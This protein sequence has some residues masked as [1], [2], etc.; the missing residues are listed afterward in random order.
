[1]RRTMA[2]GTGPV[3][4]ALILGATLSLVAL[5]GLTPAIAGPARIGPR[6]ATASGP[7]PCVP[8]GNG[9]GETCTGTFSGDLAP[10]PFNPGGFLP[11]APTVTVSQTQNLTNQMV[12]VTWT[13]FESSFVNVPNA[14][15]YVP[16]QT[17][18]AVAIVECRGTPE[19]DTTNGIGSGGPNG[20]CYALAPGTQS[21]TAAG[22]G[23]ELVTFT[24]Q[25][26]NDHGGTGSA[27]FQIET[28]Q[29]NTFLGCSDTV[30]CSLVVVPDFG[31]RQLV[32]R[33]QTTDCTDHSLDGA[34]GDDQALDNTLGYVCSWADR[35]VVPLTFAPTPGDNCPAQDAQFNAEGAPGLE[36]AMNQWL[37]G[38]CKPAAQGQAP[39]IMGYDSTVNEYLATQNFLG[40]G[41][42]LSATTDVALVTDPPSGSATNGARPFTYAPVGV[43][44]ISIVYY[45]DNQTDG[46]PITNLVLNARLVAKLLTQSYALSYGQCNTQSNPNT[47]SQ[48]CDPAVTNNPVDIFH[49]PEFQQLNPQYTTANFLPA[50]SQDAAPD[51]LPTV[52]AGDSQLTFELTRWVESDPEARA[53]LQGQPDQWGTHVNDNYRG[54]DY[55]TQQFLP[56]DPGWNNFPNPG[57]SMQLSWNPIS[58]LDN[59]VQRFAGNSSTA[60]FDKPSCSLPDWNGGPCAGGNWNFP[61]DSPQ[62]IGG[63]ALFAVV[64]QGTAAA[65][66]FPVAKILNAAGNAVAPTTK[67]MT[68]AVNDMATNPDKITQ[69]ANDNSTDPNQYPL[70]T[71]DYAMVPTCG[72]TQTK[73]TAISQFLTNVATTAQEFGTG[74]GFLPEFGGYLALDK[75]QAAQT[76]QAATQVG[77]QSCTTPPPDTTVAGQAAGNPAAASSGSNAAGTG[78][79]TAGNAAAGSTPST[80]ANRGAGTTP[81]GNPPSKSNVPLGLKSFDTN[82]FAT[83][84]LPVSLGLG[85]LLALIAGLTYALNATARGRHLRDR[86]RRTL[87]MPP[88]VDEIGDAE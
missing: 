74:P 13:N 85:G 1:M 81:S 41:Q 68:A 27:D 9:T 11:G 82:G 61:H 86:I 66:R 53:F 39:V 32:L 76:Q 84:V 88:P 25:D 64:D 44:G 43:S 62:N 37:P 73:A 19:I 26:A 40:S 36:Q 18:N 59:V 35:I 57:E 30:P 71:V 7:T 87:G 12:H 16:N 79:N 54:G 63:R 17:D 46:T 65:F 49:D 72:L 38:W 47:P 6:A 60:L 23:N 21:G 50:N 29:Q 58:G 34:F 42:A 75:D 24:S 48:I 55:P 5:T 15:G 70:T 14:V 77:T 28:K 45:V 83:Y 20:T 31:G 33:G 4:V 10:D 22:P 3:R 78:G 2:R 8:T 52:L 69:F 56:K 51:F 67:S 80:S